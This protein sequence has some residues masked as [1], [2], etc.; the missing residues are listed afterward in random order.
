MG[1][2]SSS[3]RNAAAAEAAPQVLEE[4]PQPPG[5]YSEGKIA[6]ATV[7]GPAS[8]GVLE[9]SAAALAAGAA[10]A[11]EVR[12]PIKCDLYDRACRVVRTAD[13]AR[14]LEWDARTFTSRIERVVCSAADVVVETRH[15]VYIARR[16]LVEGAEALDD[17]EVLDA[18]PSARAAERHGLPPP[19]GS[20]L[21]VMQPSEVDRASRKRVAAEAMAPAED[22]HEDD[23]VSSLEDDDDEYDGDDGDAV[24]EDEQWER[25]EEWSPRPP[26]EHTTT[27]RTP[28]PAPKKQK[29]KRRVVPEETQRATTGLALQAGEYTVVREGRGRSGA[30]VTSDRSAERGSWRREADDDPVADDDGRPPTRCCREGGGRRCGRPHTAASSSSAGNHDTTS[31]LRSPRCE[32]GCLLVFEFHRVVWDLRVPTALESHYV[33]GLVRTSSLVEDG[34]AANNKTTSH[35]VDAAGRHWV[36]VRDDLAP[37]AD[38]PSNAFV[39]AGLFFCRGA[40]C[41]WSPQCCAGTNARG[42]VDDPGGT[43]TRDATC[44]YYSAK[45]LMDLHVLPY[46]FAAV[47]HQNRWLFDFQHV[48]A[49][50][51]YARMVFVDDR[52]LNPSASSC[53]NNDHEDGHG[54]AQQPV[55]HRVGCSS[56]VAAPTATPPQQ[57]RCLTTTHAGPLQQHPG[58]VYAARGA[59]VSP[60][61]GS[62]TFAPPPPV[63]RQPAP[64]TE[65]SSRRPDL[66]RWPSFSELISPP[67]SPRRPDTLAMPHPTSTATA[68]CG[69]GGALL[70]ADTLTQS[71]G[72]TLAYV[73]D[74]EDHDFGGG[75]GP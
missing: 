63:A 33:R 30:S 19:Q 7:Q 56:T 29:K 57:Y 5:K 32:N 51:Q 39:V 20:E 65:V 18:G 23:S 22:D 45:E 52:L 31:S 59:R 35:V 17:D 24:D 28:S 47:S 12:K 21:A 4:V 6:P 16:E 46:D 70:D 26:L 2:S 40:T 71:D 75:G 48:L 27:R 15:S 34:A 69:G 60:P 62:R 41:R 1:A 55:A 67:D 68:S 14:G 61:G 9:P 58:G 3:Q 13:G 38:L 43:T 42:V 36:K 53:S 64:P 72:G 66:P 73:A 49:Y 44:S 54:A 10:V 11:R 25:G 37:L 8:P 74:E 50:L